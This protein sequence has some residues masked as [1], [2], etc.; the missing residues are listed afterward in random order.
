[1]ITYK[2]NVYDDGSKAWYLNEKLDR[3]DG[4]AVEYA[5]GTKQWWFCGEHLTEEQW[6][7]KVSKDKPKELSVE[8]ISKLLGYEVK[9]VKG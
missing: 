3:R 6:K 7:K 2:I 1:M 9:I 8:E 4:P 5:D